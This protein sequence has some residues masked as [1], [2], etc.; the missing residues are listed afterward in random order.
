MHVHTDASRQIH[1]HIKTCRITNKETFTPAQTN[2]ANKQALTYRQTNKPR[3]HTIIHA[4]K[5]NKA[6]PAINLNDYFYL[7]ILLFFLRWFFPYFCIIHSFIFICFSYSFYL[8]PFC[9]IYFLIYV[10]Y[11][12]YNYSFLLIYVL[13]LFA[14]SRPPWMIKYDCHVA[15]RKLIIKNR[16]MY[17]LFW[18]FQLSEIVEG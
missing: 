4:L 12:S 13:L 11:F 14:I 17:V 2:K 3:T 5:N 6:D 7:F 18:L 1:T 10:Y 9:N 15:I 8:F 16:V